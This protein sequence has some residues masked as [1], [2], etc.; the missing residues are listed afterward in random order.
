MLSDPSDDRIKTPSSMSM[1]DDRYCEHCDATVGKRSKHCWVCNKCISDFDHH[2]IWL[3]NCVG[4]KTYRIFFVYITTTFLS[5]LSFGIV[6]ISIIAE[7][8]HQSTRI[9]NRVPQIYGNPFDPLLYI[10]LVAFLTLLSFAPTFL[11][12][13]LLAFHIKLKRLNMSTY[14]YILELRAKEEAKGKQK[15]WKTKREE[16]K[17]PQPTLAFV[18]DSPKHSKKKDS[19]EL[20]SFHSGI[21]TSHSKASLPPIHPKKTLD[22]D[23]EEVV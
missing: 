16:K 11:V 8:L 5:S 23:R 2:C 12:G 22:S 4:G 7:F 1:E 10:V 20:Q 18:E 21:E 3:N 13:Q 9:R 17:P 15:K 19:I 6:G 14:D